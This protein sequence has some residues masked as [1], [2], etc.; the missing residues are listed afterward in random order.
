MRLVMAKPRPRPRFFVVTKSS[1]IAPSRSAGMP[2]PVSV[3]LTSTLSR[4]LTVA[5]VTRPPACVA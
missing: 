1:K 4:F 5:I 2:E 3:T